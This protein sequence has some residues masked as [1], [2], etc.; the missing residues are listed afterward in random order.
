MTT[1]AVLNDPA[2]IVRQVQ[3]I[4][5]ALCKRK[6]WRLRIPKD[7]YRIHDDWLVVCAKPN[8]AGV[9]AYDHVELLSAA[10]KQLRGQGIENVVLVPVLE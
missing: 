2:A 3:A 10:E 6:S 7:G 4:L 8:R 9:R 1:A 5:D